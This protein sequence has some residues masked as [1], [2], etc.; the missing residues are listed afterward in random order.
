M[1]TGFQDGRLGTS[2]DPTIERRIVFVAA[3]MSAVFALFGLRLFQLQILEGA[4]L[5]KVSKNNSV[6]SV[7]V[8]A[9]RGLILDREGREI[10][11][12]RPA[13]QV[14]VI[15]NDVRD[16][17][18]LYRALGLLMN[19]E[20]ALLADL[21]GDPVG[22]RRFQPVVVEGDTPYDVLARV[23]SHRHALPGVFT[24]LR[25]RRQYVEHELAA[26]LLGSMGEIQKE[27]LE[28]SGPM[29]HLGDFVGQ[30][31][32]E[33]RLESHLHGRVGGRNL[34]VDVLGR[35]VE[36]LGKIDAVPGGRVVLAIDLDLQRVAEEELARPLPPPDP[37]PEDWAPS[38]RLGAVV[39][40]DPRNGDVLAMVS[41]PAY[42]PNDFAGGIDSETWSRLTGDEWEPL[43]NRAIAGL[44]SPGSTY[45]AVVAAAGL[46]EGI[47][48][49]EKTVFCPGYFRLGRRTYRCWKRGGHGDVDLIESLRQSC[50]VYYY[51]LGI[52]LGIDTIARYAKAFG[53]GQ[54]TGIRLAN[55]KAGLIPTM[56]WK[57]KAVGERWMKGETVSAS[58]GQG[59]NLVSPLQLAVAYAAIANGG[60]LYVP[61]LVKRLETWQGELV[62][63]IAVE[64]R[65][66]VELPPEVL[67][68][69]REGLT[70]VV[71]DRGG[72]GG[73]ARIPGTTVAGK[74]GTTQVVALER[75]KDMEDEEI[76]M[77][78]RDHA[79]FV[80]F[81]PA[82]A[83]E[84][85]VAVVIEHAGRGGGA[86]A[87]PV[88]Q[89]VMARYFE[90]FPP[91]VP[92]MAKL[93]PW[94]DGDGG[95]DDD[96]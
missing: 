35:E 15:P 75:V 44:Y 91:P 62:E 81:A 88:A 39:A 67:A 71:M 4:N 48:D 40:L 78:W 9:P 12:A 96:D 82:E 83:P 55:E 74:T 28:R 92:V 50:D 19:R 95:T 58:I 53:L 23:R 89:A 52:E 31:G 2:D 30:A 43:T 3:C 60:T 18:R 65:G 8:E 63:E 37:Q 49:P 66:E 1:P 5:S 21:V 13:Y 80:A 87:A 45:K 61:R 57:E 94:A 22:R 84:I 24:D 36:E 32:L 16:G 20:P 46:A 79:L 70:A 72:T 68:K 90:K 73:R 33:R 76:P 14:Q 25:P 27:Q 54:P 42:D 69:V 64:K 10:A 6:R 17:E 93:D 59:F 77:R 11:T 26:H 51:Q 7:R 29:Y 38:P 34:V 41:L 86:A 56:A 47:V 85:V